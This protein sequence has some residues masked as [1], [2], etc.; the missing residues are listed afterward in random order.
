LSLGPLDRE[1]ASLLIL[2]PVIGSFLG[3]IICRL[4]EGRIV[5]WSRSRCDRCETLLQPRDLVPLLS[6]AIQSGRCRHCGERLDWFY[7][8]IEIAA[9]LV[10]AAAVLGDGTPRAWLD[11]LFGWWLLTLA[12]IDLRQWILPD[13]LTLPLIVA[14]LT[15][16]AL[17][18]PDTLLDRALGAAIGYLMVRALAAT[19]RA[20]RHRDGLGGGDA[21]LVCAAGAWLGLAALP[22]VILAAALLG[23]VAAAALRLGGVRVHGGMALPFGTLLALPA[24]LIWL[25]GPVSL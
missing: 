23:L 1:G 21:K 18:D 24:W 8:A 13:L 9:L 10:A 16:A 15:E 12:W 19:Y 2:A 14:G 20:L 22:Q 3:V 17:F 25:C 11:C 6:W 7:P 5:G 4:P